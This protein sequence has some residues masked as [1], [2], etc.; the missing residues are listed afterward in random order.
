GQM[1]TNAAREATRLAIVDGSSNSSVT[2][3]VESF[4][5][6][7]LGVNASDVNVVITVDP[8]PGNDDPLDKIEDAQA[9]DLVTIKVDVPFDKVS[10][11]P[12]DYLSGKK[13]KAQS[14]MRHE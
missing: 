12:G 3:W 4:L 7:T 10:Y 5:N 11:I 1:V 2:A 14:A 9:R 13:L 6:D 8:A